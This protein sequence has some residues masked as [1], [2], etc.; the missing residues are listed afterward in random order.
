[1]MVGHAEKEH[2]NATGPVSKV[3][4]ILVC[5]FTSGRSLTAEAMH[6]RQDIREWRECSRSLFVQFV[7][8]F[9]LVH[10]SSGPSRHVHPA[11]MSRWHSGHDDFTDVATSPARVLGSTVHRVCSL[12][13]LCGRRRDAAIR[14]LAGA[15]ACLSHTVV[16][17]RSACRVHGACL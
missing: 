13:S 16:S 12:T 7:L 8:Y 10:F 2:L 3:A 6:H 1:M 15:C 11:R 4:R 17:V 5:V 9:F 14:G